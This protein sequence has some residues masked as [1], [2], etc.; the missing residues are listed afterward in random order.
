MTSDVHD[1]AL[2][3]IANDYEG[4]YLKSYNKVPLILTGI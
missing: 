4:I 3:V 2:L 1:D